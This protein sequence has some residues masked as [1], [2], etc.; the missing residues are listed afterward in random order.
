MIL[1]HFKGGLSS[2]AYHLEVNMQQIKGKS[3]NLQ[4]FAIPFACMSFPFLKFTLIILALYNTS[5]SFIFL[6]LIPSKRDKALRGLRALS[7]LRDLMAPSS[8]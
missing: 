6:T 8:E 4:G 7:V 5:R 3:S 1:Y 2:L